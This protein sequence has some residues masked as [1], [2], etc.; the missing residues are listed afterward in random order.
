DGGAPRCASVLPVFT[1]GRGDGPKARVRTLAGRKKRLIA[2]TSYS[3]ASTGLQ[4]ERAGRITNNVMLLLLAA[5][6]SLLIFEQ[7]ATGWLT[8]G[9]RVNISRRDFNTTELIVMA[10]SALWGVFALL[11]A[12][13]VAF[14]GTGSVRRYFDREGGMPASVGFTTATLTVIGTVGALIAVQIITGWLPLGARANI[15]RSNIN[16]LEW[17]AFGLAALWALLSLRTAWGLLMRQR[18]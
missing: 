17:V 14:N 13:R 10:A 18:P 4:Q 9:E 2:M 12:L 16:W 8:F 3:P 1:N 6:L 5:F 7:V 11:T 15:P